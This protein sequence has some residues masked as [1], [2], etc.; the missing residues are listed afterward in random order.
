MPIVQ[1]LFD[2]MHYSTIERQSIKFLLIFEFNW[3][4]LTS[5][6]IVHKRIILASI[7]YNLEG[8]SNMTKQSN[9]YFLF[10]FD[11][12]SIEFHNRNSIVQLAFSRIQIIRQ[13]KSL[14]DYTWLSAISSTLHRKNF[15][16]FRERWQ[17]TFVPVQ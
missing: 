7:E 5:I 16:S 11:C 8:P 3:V 6:M 10:F 15:R 14:I 1:L 17:E 4:Q 9:F 2:C 12:H 13:S